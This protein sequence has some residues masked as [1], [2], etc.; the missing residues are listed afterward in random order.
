MTQH[1]I[2]TMWELYGCGMEPIAAA[3]SAELNVPLHGQAFSS[4]EIEESAAEREKEGSF[5]RWMRSLTPA[6]API[7]GGGED[8][9][10]VMEERSIEDTARMVRADVA[11]FAAEGGVILGRNGAFLLQGRPQALHVKLVGKLDERVERAAALTGV[12]QQRAAKRQPIEDDFR[13]D[14]ALRIFRFDPLDDDYYDLVIDTTRFSMQDAVAL[15]IQ[16]AKARAA[17]A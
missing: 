1:Q 4:E 13:R 3:V 8:I 15:I 7:G 5:G 14:L 2:I 17:A 9:A 11:S 12:T 16:A 10:R 6:V